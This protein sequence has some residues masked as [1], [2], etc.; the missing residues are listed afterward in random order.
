ML[1]D[2][3]RQILLGH[4]VLVV[5]A[6]VAVAASGGLEPVATWPG[7]IESGIIWAEGHVPSGRRSWVTHARGLV[8]LGLQGDTPLLLHVAEMITEKLGGR[9]GAEYRAWLHSTVGALPLVDPAVPKALAALNIPIVTTNY[10]DLIEQATGWGTATWMDPYAV[11]RAFRESE[12]TV[13]HLHGHW[14]VPSSVV[15]GVR[16]YADVLGNSKIQALQHIIAANKSLIFVGVG[17]GA[18][19]PNFSALRDWL[20]ATFPNSEYRHFRLCLRSEAAELIGEFHGERIVP[21]VYGDSYRDLV[22]FVAE[23]AP[24]ASTQQSR[25]AAIGSDRLSNLRADPF[26]N[27]FVGRT[28]L[29]GQ[30]REILR[31]SEQLGSPRILALRGSMGIGKSRTAKEYAR[32]NASDYQI[33]WW[34]PAEQQATAQQA[35]AQLGLSLGLPIVED[36]ERA[37]DAVV[38]RLRALRG[39]LLIF[40]NVED[41]NDVLP[42]FPA[43][44]T[45]HIIV[46]TRLGPGQLRPDFQALPVPPLPER[47]AVRLVAPE[48]IP[49]A[50]PALQA[51]CGELG[52][53][54]LALVWSR[55]ALSQG[56]TP[57]QIL[58]EIRGHAPSRAERAVD[59]ASPMVP[60]SLAIEALR[61]SSADAADLLALCS[62]LG[63]GITTDSLIADPSVRPALPDNLQRV[64]AP[65]TCAT[66]R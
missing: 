65:S 19:D 50:H 28:E 5:G 17:A 10:D 55:A 59:T 32:L 29:L 63:P 39:F 18:G 1:A 16:S 15:L 46:T 51:L 45:G 12:A 58:A 30:M 11:Q 48:G 27:E 57:R 54:P 25:H 3:R 56:S 34:I 6:G 23:L 20:T 42:Y 52:H 8:E 21:V 44:D 24:T 38:A 14:K 4:A 61:E 13:V 41:L 36:L 22:E 66:C 64:A 26:A 9:D 7:L 49:I 40:D 62:F 37:C 35:I 53:L 31:T 60:W 47:D 2:L 43:C 33:R